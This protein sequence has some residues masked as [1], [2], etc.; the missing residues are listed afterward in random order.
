MTSAV[1]MSRSALA[2]APAAR[3]I[4][5]LGATGSIGASTIDLIHRNRERFRV[6]AVRGIQRV[7]ISTT[8]PDTGEE[9][10]NLGS[11]KK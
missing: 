4:T 7:V 6:E 11:G 1:P 9:I 10:N 2:T 5:I 8:D 3:T